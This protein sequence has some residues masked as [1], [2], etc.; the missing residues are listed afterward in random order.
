MSGHHASRSEFQW[1]PAVTLC[2]RLFPSLALS[3]S[4]CL[5]LTHSLTH[6]VTHTRSVG[7]GLKPARPAQAACVKAW[8][9]TVICDGD[10]RTG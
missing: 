9:E 6:S 2:H 3:L 1:C 5:S 4:L 10:C 7:R 8:M